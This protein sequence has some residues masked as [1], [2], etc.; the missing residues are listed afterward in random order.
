M[1]LF[2]FTGQSGVAAGVRRIETVT[3]P[4][5]YQLM[6]KTE[7]RLREVAQTLKAQPEYVLRKLHQLQQDRERL[8]G[9]L[10][11]LQRAG[12]NGGGPGGEVLDVKGIALTI[13]D[14]AAED[15]GEVG[16]LAD[17]FRESR[18]KGVLVLFGSA[19]RGAIHVAVTDDLVRA[20]RKAGDLVSRIA[21]RCGG[22]GGGRP[23][24]AS[25]GIGDPTRLSG[26][27]AELPALVATWL[28][29]TGE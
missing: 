12:G 28:E 21:A 4:A 27:R 7:N 6:E 10:V 16:A 11:E 24:F 23:Q 17:R 20:G 2:R 5:A 19:G 1:G 8:E 22:K 14:T 25:A 26:L 9:K 18:T 29:G 3:G 13:G 15:R